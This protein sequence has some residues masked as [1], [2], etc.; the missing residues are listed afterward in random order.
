[1]WGK[2]RR[3]DCDLRDRD[4]EPLTIRAPGNRNG[5]VTGRTLIHILLGCAFALAVTLSPAAA[6]AAT[7]NVT[8][9]SDSNAGS[10]LPGSCTLRQAVAAVNGG[11][12]GDTITVPAGLYP[13][14]FGELPLQKDVTIDG[15]GS[16]ATLIDGNMRSRI[17]NVAAPGVTVSI[18]GLAVVNGRVAGTSAAL[19]QGGGILNSG[20]LTLDNVLVRGNF[21]MPADSS[22]VITYGGGIFNAGILR[23]S[24][25][26]IESNHATTL[27]FGGGIS[28]GAGIANVGG[29]VELTDSVLSNNVAK[30][31]AVSE[32]GGLRS[33]S[34]TP[35]GASVTLTRVLVDGNRSA[36]PAGAA[37]GSGGGIDVSRTDLTIRESA[38]T[39][40]AASAAVIAQGG[41]I[42]VGGEG[43][44]TLERSLVSG[45]F[46]EGPSA[47]GAGL[48]ARSEAGEVWKIGDSTITG[49]RGTGTTLAEGGGILHSGGRLDVLSSTISGN[50]VSGGGATDRGGNLL[51]KGE[52][53]SVL[54]LRDSIVSSGGGAA[55]SENCF[56]PGV[57]SAGHNIDSLDQCNFNSVG[58]R[59]KTDPLLAS[60][61]DNGG[62]TKTLALSPGSPAVDAGDAGCPATDQRGVPRPQGAACD[63]GAF[64]LIP[65]P[66][67]AAAG[68]AA[69]AARVCVVPKLRGFKL[70][71]SR[72]K[73]KRA[74][75]RLGK[76]RGKKSRS[77]RVKKQ[78]AKPRTVL[79]LDSRVSVKL[80]AGAHGRRAAM[81]ASL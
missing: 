73:L 23:V 55:G 25:S 29:Q 72:K 2:I 69:V 38:V 46:A 34:S 63:I 14:A 21:V 11:G 8:T 51:D 31:Q 47:E 9:E 22:G 32:G 53:G 43:N 39:R 16:A 45:N 58:D 1:M 76:V 40:N 41:G 56:G 3:P 5:R 17:L 79:P 57:Q 77:A 37:I 10:C 28:E 44:F 65:P 19:A 26:T 13:L 60:L 33:S 80:G 4:L 59:V 70:K 7:F 15:A 36:V 49:N 78:S 71:A 27:P 42:Q 75:C 6:N 61:A 67:S 24:N 52:G 12:G 64:E 30:S 66:P 62:P 81:D 68:P 50:V 48:V 18:R 74:G 35:H 54:S 20:T